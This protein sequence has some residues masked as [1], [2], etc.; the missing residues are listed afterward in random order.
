MIWLTISSFLRCVLTVLH[1]F[2]IDEFVK[3]KPPGRKMVYILKRI[4]SCEGA[5]L[6]V[7]MYV[8]PSVCNQ[9]EILKVPSFQKVQ[10]SSRR[11]Q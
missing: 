3:S 7:L 6:E 5:A 11:L 9:F 1:A 8:C 4:F 10:E 2:I